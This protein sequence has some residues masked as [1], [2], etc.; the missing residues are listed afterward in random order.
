MLEIKHLKKSYKLGKKNETPV[1]KDINMTIQDGEFAAIIGKSGSGKSTLLN[2]ISGLDTDY[3]GQVLY[4]G[5]DLQDIDLDVYHLNHIG[6]IFQSF[7]L[8]NHMSVIEN[9][10]IPLYLN[11]ELSESDR[12]ARA[13]DLLSQVGLDEFASK[14]PTQLSGGQKQRVAIA[15]SLA[16]NPDMIIA[17]EP[18]GALDSVT[19]AGIIKLLKDLAA[20]G[21]TVIVVTHDL[22]IADQTDAV[23]RLADG[24]VISFERKKEVSQKVSH[25]NEKKLRLNWW[26]TAKISFKSF[27]NR[28]FR[29]LLVALGT[30]IGI[31]AILLA[32]GLGNGVNQSLSKIFGTTFSPNQITT[33]YKE[34]GGSRSPEPTTPLTSSEIKK[35][36]Q[37]YEA[38]N[39]TEIYERTTIQGIKFE[40]DGQYLNDISAE[41]QEANFKASRYEDLTVKDEYLLSGKMVT[42]NKTGAVIPSSVA[43][44]ILGK[45]DS[46][47]LTKSDG[48]KLIGKKITLVYAGRNS[49]TKN[50]VKIETTIS[51][52]T[53]PSKEG[54]ARGFDVS[55]KTMND[56]IKMTGIEKPI[57]SVDA[58]TKT[59]AQAEE[60]VEKYE[61]DKD[62]ANYSITNAN[63]FVDTFS[64]FTD[65]IVY[66]IAFI[67]GLSLA[68]AGVMIAIV[69][70][71]GV[72]ERTREIGVFR[73]IGYRKRHIRGL[74]M[75]EASYIIILANMLSSLVAVT[76]AKIA[77]PILETKIGFEDMIHISFWN[78]LVT[79]AITITIG[80]I[81]SIYPSNK[82]AKLDAAE[83]LRSE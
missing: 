70:Y 79:L 72:V 47:D 48:D 63:A 45:K 76:I 57:L 68:V 42:S 9:V 2:I 4:N 35:I 6:F 59:T 20:K 61:D 34:D 83:A 37:L 46:D 31:I 16:N 62:W 56:F 50:T 21:T 54:F 12:N 44:A 32:F 3:S 66:L 38:E 60:I 14:K 13:L 77:S 7:H 73:A 69:L 24:E 58:F 26:A 15:R 82:A 18:T 65:I 41:M 39:I 29:N 71:I 1:L 74:F 64:Q 23:L 25:K 81:F 28:K 80:F 75:M 43:K 10:K 11:A 53:N 40:Y 55:T 27:F 78:F 52:I 51:G 30:S 49:D 33:Y 8:V 22:N 36:K 5:D 67:A 19:S 17:D